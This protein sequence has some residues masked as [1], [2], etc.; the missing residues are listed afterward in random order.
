MQ[1]ASLERV[2]YWRDKWL[3]GSGPERDQWRNEQDRTFLAFLMHLVHLQPLDLDQLRVLVAHSGLRGPLNHVK[4]R[5]RVSLDPDHNLFEQEGLLDFKG[6]DYEVVLVTGRLTDNNLE[7]SQFDVVLISCPAQHLEEAEGLIIAAVRAAAPGARVGIN[8]DLAES[9]SPDIQRIQSLLPKTISHTLKL[10]SVGLGR[11][12]LRGSLT[13]AGASVLA[14]TDYVRLRYKMDIRPRYTPNAPNQ[15]LLSNIQ[16]GDSNYAKKLKIY[17]SYSTYL[18]DITPNKINEIDPY[19][20]NGWVPT[21]DG[22]SLYVETV[23]K[24]PDVFIEIGSG[25]STKFVRRA[26]RDHKLSTK[27]ISIDPH[28]RAEIDTLCD[29]IYRSRLEDL[30]LNLFDQIGDKSAILFFDGSHY[31]FQNSDVVVFFLELMPRLREKWLVGVHD[32]FLPCDYMNKGNRFFNEQY[33]LAPFLLCN[34]ILTI[35]PSYYV[36]MSPQFKDRVLTLIDQPLQSPNSWYGGAI[37]WYKLNP[38]IRRRH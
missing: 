15:W 19:W 35:M 32:I 20:H 14:E 28:P 38:S 23:A 3:Q 24:K 34:S 12:A 37:Y 17:K 11:V 33:M 36:S 18:N 21:L 4:A 26:I 8:I 6:R 1:I 13:C 29:T 5:T 27:I 16:K 22:I 10:I 9:S 2:R 7:A 31:A 30:D 25:N